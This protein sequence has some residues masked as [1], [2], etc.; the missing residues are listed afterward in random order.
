MKSPYEVIKRP[1][2]TEKS[3]SLLDENKYT[4]EVDKNANKPEIKAAIEEIFDGVKVKKVR[5][6]NSEGKK[7]RTRHG[8][9]KKADWKKAVVTLT[10]DSAEI[11]YFEGL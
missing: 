2:I 9:G 5:T 3:M 8:I 10:E 1:I 7:V 11:E 6:M 4:F